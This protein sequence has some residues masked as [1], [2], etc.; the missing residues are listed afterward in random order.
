MSENES[1]CSSIISNVNLEIEGFDPVQEDFHMIRKFLNELLTGIKDFGKIDTSDIANKIISQAGKIG[2]VLKQISSEDG[3][4]KAK[5]P[6]QEK[7]TESIEEEDEAILGVCSVLKAS[8]LSKH[9]KSSLELET[10]NSVFLISDRLEA[11]PLQAGLPLLSATLSELK[12]FSKNLDKI[13]IIARCHCTKKGTQNSE[14]LEYIQDE[15]TFLTGQFGIK[16]Y[17][18]YAIQGAEPARRNMWEGSASAENDDDKDL[19]EQSEPLYP[20]RAM[21]KVDLETLE[22]LTQFLVT[23]LA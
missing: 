10:D 20:Y 9:L 23:V 21:F 16:P 14:D 7:V 13:H 5:N 3:E 4:S 19:H 17:K 12:D 11:M 15:F 1:E 8:D 2:S 6:K 22:K 18:F